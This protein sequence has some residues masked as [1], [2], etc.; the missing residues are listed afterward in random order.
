M[1]SQDTENK[2][3]ES[4]LIA[5]GYVL[6]PRGGGLMSY[7]KECPDGQ[8]FISIAYEGDENSAAGSDPSA[9]DYSISRES[10]TTMGYLQ[11]SDEM[12]LKTALDTASTLMQRGSIGSAG[13]C[14][15]TVDDLLNVSRY[16]VYDG[17]TLG[18]IIPH[19]EFPR[20]G[21]LAS[22]ITDGGTHN[23]NNG[24]IPLSPDASLRQ[25]TPNDFE[26]F[27]VHSGGYFDNCRFEDYSDE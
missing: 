5:A 8:D 17:H 9:K 10:R 12:D 18:F 25:A 14:S 19:D 4:M 13:I 15:N 27:R 24:P 26:Y 3:S 16:V 6:T 11:S 1:T 23:P 2:S 22:K 20:L 7:C 21:V